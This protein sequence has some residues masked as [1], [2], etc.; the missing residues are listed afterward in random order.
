MN[1]RTTRRGL[2]LIALLAC[3]GPFAQAQDIAP[4]TAPA[5]IAGPDLAAP[6]RTIV[7]EPDSAEGPTEAVARAAGTSP[8]LRVAPTSVA[9]VVDGRLDDIC[10]QNAPIISEFTQVEPAEG[11]KPTERT[12]VRVLYD[13]D[14]LYFA[15]RC[16]D[17]DARKIV[18]KQLQQDADQTSDDNITLTFDTFGQNRAGYLFR[19]NPAGAREDGLIETTGDLKTAWDTIWHGYSRVDHE[20][21]TT[22]IAIPFKS[23]AF[24]PKRTVWGFNIERQIRRRQEIVRWAF[25]FKNKTISSLTDL[26]ELQNLSG[27]R[28]GL[29]L[30]I[31]PFLAGRYRHQHGD[32]EFEFKPGLDVFY[33]ITPA[34]TAA[35]TLNTDFAE[36]EVDTR[37]VNLTRFP[38]FFP[39]KR[40]FFLQDGPLFSFNAY[41]GP[42]PF[43]SRRIGLGPS[44]ENLDIIAGGKLTGRIGELGVGLLNV[45]V[46]SGKDVSSTN[47][48]AA[49]LS[50]RVLEESS[51]GG[52]FTYGDPRGTGDNWLAGV[53]LNY[54]NSHLFGHDIL[55]AQ[56]W[57]LTSNQ[58]DEAAVALGGALRFPND[59][60]WIEASA[61]Q[62][63]ED[64]DPALGFV[65]RRGVRRYEGY[66]RYRW[67]PGGYVR[68]VDFEF[69]PQFYTNLDNIVETDSWTA[70]SI[71]ILNQRGDAL[72]L[73][74]VSERENL[75]ENFEIQPGVN[76]PADDYR[77]NRGFGVISTTTANPVSAFASFDA[78]QFYHGTSQKYGGGIEWRVS[79]HLFFGLQSEVEHVDLPAG[80]FNVVVSSARVNVSLTTDLS[81]NTL[82][83]HDNVSEN[84]G[85]Y[86]RIKWTMRP[87][88]DVYLVFKNGFDVE[89]GRFR[90]RTTEVSMKVGWTFRF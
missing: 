90:N 81:W 23:L 52:I 62:I 76:I 50:Y 35:F 15:V 3:A 40:A 69:A 84:V 41:N 58:S 44:G 39:E 83:Q 2:L 79:P 55:S 61:S 57:L 7:T 42:L 89:D 45:Q 82:V 67:R 26:G 71:R 1:A 74:F 49:R 27:L 46:D 25:P 30:E 12:E 65:S 29:G 19:V 80:E 78:G 85:V 10:W 72:Y 5:E 28:K 73:G 20:G 4:R 22:E 33:S 51:I 31:K 70:P 54:R 86:S 68:Y 59:P 48:S 38:L 75:F 14:S 17:K 66:A 64:F 63:D 11:A 37:Q 16:Y 6:P 88:S 60:W 8:S 36:A 9:P 53:D 56:S 21:W 77:F 43:Y 13:R 18:A 34:L 24:D 32:G 87:G 47:L